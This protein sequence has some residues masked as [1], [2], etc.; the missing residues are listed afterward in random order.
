MMLVYWMEW[1]SS[2]VSAN[3]FIGHSCTTEAYI[4][5]LLV[6]N[7]VCRKISPP[8]Q[9]IYAISVWS[10]ES[11]FFF[12]FL[13]LSLAR[14]VLHSSV[15]QLLTQPINP[16]FCIVRL[17]I[18]AF[19][20]SSLWPAC[21][22]ACNR[23]P[24]FLHPCFSAHWHSALPFHDPV[25]TLKKYNFG[26]ILFFSLPHFPYPLYMRLS[27]QIS[28]RRTLQWVFNSPYVDVVLFWIPTFLALNKFDVIM[29]TIMQKWIECSVSHF[30]F[31]FFFFFS[32]GIISKFWCIPV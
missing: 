2:A 26:V 5:P 12:L 11:I 8:F 27:W 31:F 32:D 7:S 17:L 20:F 28:T 6:H 16:F 10:G 29:Y 24:T 19:Y 22:N 21:M 9:W 4:R 3:G 13:S 1:L 25:H 30:L 18:A 15:S 14:N 23:S